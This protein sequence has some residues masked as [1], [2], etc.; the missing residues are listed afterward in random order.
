[1][2]RDVKQKILVILG[3]TGVG[4]SAL[5]LELA[6]RL[7]AEIVMADSQSVLR[8][9][10]IGTAKPSLEERAEVPHHLLDVADFGEAFDASRYAELADCAIADIA[11]RGK[12]PLISG[13][14]GLYLKALLHGF[15]EAPS[16][17]EDFRR[18]LEKRIEEEGLP[19]VYLELQSLDPERASEIHPNDAVRIIRALEICH[20]SGAKPSELAKK[21][22]FEGSKYEAL[23]IGLKLPREEL[24]QRIDHRVLTMLNQGWVEEVR[25][26]LRKGHD[27]LNCRTQTIGYPTL[28]RLVN[29]EIF[30]NDAIAEIQR[31]TRQFAKRQLAWFRSDPEIHWFHPQDREAILALVLRHFSGKKE[32]E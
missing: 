32:A 9:F 23:K 14:T 2:Q 26:L 19:A 24:Y 6:K 27:L 1:M 3:P 28:A 13:G 11:A 31:E 15:M 18:A 4:K 12:L 16:R 20:C 17:D 29:G 10:D 8:G 30:V 7:N 5:S 22:R 21:H 25:G